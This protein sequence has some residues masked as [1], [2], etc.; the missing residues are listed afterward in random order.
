MLTKYIILGLVQGL[1]EFL[2]VSSSGHLVILQHYFSLDNNC[3]LVNLTLHA[4]TLLAV[5]LFF[6]KDIRELLRKEKLKLLIFIAA[7]TVITG[8][9][10]IAGNDFFK[11]L[12]G[13]AGLV[14]VMLI[15]NG[16]VLLFTR[17]FL[18]GKRKFSD[19]NIIDALWLGISQSLAIIPGISRSGL[20]ISALL[21]RGV[22]KESAFRF[23]FLASIPVILGALIF[24]LKDLTFSTLDIPVYPLLTG[25]VTAFISG[26][27]ALK[28]LSIVIRRAKLP[29]FG[30]YCLAIAFI[31]L[32]LH[33]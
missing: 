30:Y 29:F 27:F 19:L 16:I 21:A 28:I 25:V 10:G 4:G 2:P 24:E 32:F 7:A 15:I 11:T 5:I 23:S 18:N 3:C 33:T 14:C 20:T 9:C 12:F 17:K 8:V 13:S 1:T 31:Y 26:L 22:K 6:F